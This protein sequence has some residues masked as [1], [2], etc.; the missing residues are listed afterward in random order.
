[1]TISYALPDKQSGQWINKSI[2]DGSATSITY[3]LIQVAFQENVNYK[4]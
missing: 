4:K 3:E 1:M 2:R